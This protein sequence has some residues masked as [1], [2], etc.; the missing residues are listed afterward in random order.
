MAS[1]EFYLNSDFDLSLGGRPSLLESPDPTFVHEMAWHFLFAAG[2]GDSL[3]VHRELPD[4][5]LAY[6]EDKGLKPPRP[7]LHPRYTPGSV[8]TPFGWNSHAQSLA[9]RYPGQPAHPDLGAV[10]IAN[11]RA[12]SLALERDWAET[13]SPGGYGNLFDSLADLEGFLHER[14]EPL[15]WV[16]KGDHGHAGTANRRVPSRALSGEDRRNLALLFE[17]HGR[18]VAEPWDDRL[19]DMAINFT[20]EK[21]GGIAHFRGHQ[22]LNSRDGAFLGVKIHPSKQ[23]PEPWRSTLE[24]SGER[25]ATA[26]DALGYSGPVSVDAYILNSDQGP[27]LRPLVDINAR[28]SMAKPA[29][30]LAD[31]L[32]G[33]FL[34]WIWA[35]PR[36]LDLPDSYLG[37]DERLGPHAFRRETGTG[38]MAVSPL[39]IVKHGPG[40]GTIPG[41]VGKPGNPARPKRIGF[42]FSADDEDGLARLQT[43]F[44][45]A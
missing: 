10:K 8:F 39:S 18:V 27:R 25:L 20:V 14:T 30:G 24:A 26:L 42:L 3:I 32:P 17:Q 16:V 5:F 11:S 45:Q 33:K 35:K 13:G 43:G 23:P 38:I 1:R 6:L 9:S 31:R 7:I 22:L 37:L 12:F 19:M 4:G 15:G 40:S 36:K 2:D 34:L 28:L 41:R 21:G 44:T 29:H